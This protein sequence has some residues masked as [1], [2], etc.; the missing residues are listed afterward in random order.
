VYGQLAS[1]GA[2]NAKEAKNAK[3]VIGLD[4]N[5]WSITLNLWPTEDVQHTGLGRQLMS[6]AEQIAHKKW[7]HSLSVISWVWVRWYYQK[8]GYSLVGTYLVKHI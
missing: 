7:Y 1:L 4:F 3:E 6:L 8:L 2:E 5:L